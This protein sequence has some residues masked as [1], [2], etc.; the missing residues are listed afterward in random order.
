M[1]TL[2]WGDG[3]SGAKNILLTIIND[4]EIE[5]SEN[6]TIRLSNSTNSS[7]LGSQRTMT[8]T[9]HHNDVSTSSPATGG[10][11]GGNLSI[12]FVI[13]LLGSLRPITRK[14]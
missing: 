12:L 1:G 3:E 14:G 2:S 11:G 10:S 13:F 4:H 8:I 9:I 5:S 7:V 6:I